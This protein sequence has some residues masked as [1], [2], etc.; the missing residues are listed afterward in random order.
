MEIFYPVQQSIDQQNLFGTSNAMYTALGQ[1]GHPGI[2]FECPSGTPV[3]APIDGTATY[4]TDKYGGCGLWI[5]SP[6][7]AVNES[8]HVVILWHMYPKDTEGFPYSIPTEPG[9]FT[10]VKTGQL[11]GYS[12]NTGY[13]TESTGPHLH[14]GVFP[15]AA[16]GGTPLDPTNGY[17][18]CIDPMPF[19]N[20]QL[21]FNYPIEVQAIQTESAI[22][23][24]TATPAEKV[25]ES[26]WFVQL[27]T[28][29]FPS[30]KVA[31][32]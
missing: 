14:L 19:F 11:L 27:M 31:N 7:G 20:G 22:L 28:W 8:T 1:L 18:G 5:W 16:V 32:K 2:D 15:C 24:S 12:D 6:S 30:L 13:P 26:G 29:L 10:P 4:A 3:Y 23:S 25:Q 9:V 17:G 21:A